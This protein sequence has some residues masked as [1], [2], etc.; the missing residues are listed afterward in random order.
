MESDDHPSGVPREDQ[1]VWTAAQAL[2]GRDR[3]DASEAPSGQL[4]AGVILV[5]LERL[6][7]WVRVETP[8]QKRFWV[9][10]RRLLAPPVPAASGTPDGRTSRLNLRPIAWLVVIGAVL[11][12]VAIDISDLSGATTVTTVA[13]TTVAVAPTTVAA[14]PASPSTTRPP[15]T[16][17]TAVPV[18]TLTIA[19]W[20][21]DT[22]LQEHDGE[23]GS[24]G[25]EVD[26]VDELM[27]RLHA[28]ADWV[29]ADLAKLYNHPGSLEFDLAAGGLVVFD[30]SLL[31]IAYSAPYLNR[32][33]ALIVDP[34]S[35]S[36]PTSFTDLSSSDTVGVTAESVAVDWAKAELAPRG[37][38][39]R[40]FDLSS[41]VLAALRSGEV[42]AIVSTVMYQLAAAGRLAPLELVDALPTGQAVA[43]V[44]D[45]DQPGLLANVNE[46]LAAMIS[47]GTY[48]TI[49]DR[50]FDDASASVAR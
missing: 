11:M 8:E 42:D 21:Y 25:F 43:L 37:V 18:V 36:S 22:V 14:P 19:R 34:S 48:Q 2:P 46:A 49:Y 32:Q 5:E 35:G 38:T 20:Y 44:V 1:G 24:S 45:P 47:D 13:P 28:E 10:G 41:E 16:T 40:E 31:G 23:G 27:T 4:D 15:T 33:Y 17:S 30:S 39:V 6:G 9:D 7:L 29:D 26:L 12:A 50:W 3:P